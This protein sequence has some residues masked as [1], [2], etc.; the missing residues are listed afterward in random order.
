MGRGLA[1]LLAALLSMAPAAT[2]DW[3]EPIKLG[4]VAGAGGITTVGAG[5]AH[6]VLHADYH[7]AA[8]Y[9]ASAAVV[10]GG[11]KELYDWRLGETRRFDLRDLAIDVAGAGL[12]IASTEVT[13]SGFPW[14]HP[15]PAGEITAAT[16]TLLLAGTLLTS[17]A[18]LPWVPAEQRRGWCLPVGI[19]G[20]GGILLLVA[21][22][23]VD[24]VKSR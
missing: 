18:A 9:G 7:R 15:R 5:L 20:A 4:H 21:S 2:G 23:L 17:V 12:G 1:A 24:H 16:G 11:M 14:P 3:L 10:A 22:Y 8:W 19:T 6:G 13:A